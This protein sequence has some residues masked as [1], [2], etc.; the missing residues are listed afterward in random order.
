MEFIYNETPE[1]V[2]AQLAVIAAQLIID[3]PSGIMVTMMANKGINIANRVTDCND[4]IVL[5]ISYAA[6][7]GLSKGK[8]FEGNKIQKEI[9]THLRNIGQNGK[10]VLPF[11]T[12]LG[13][14][15]YDIVGGTLIKIPTTP[16]GLKE[17]ATALQ[18]K[19][20]SFVLP[21]CP[22]SP[23]IATKA[24]N[25]PNDILAL[26]SVITMKVDA[27][28]LRQEMVGITHTIATKMEAGEI[29]L[30]DFA[31]VIIEV[32]GEDPAAAAKYGFKTRN[33]PTVEKD[34]ITNLLPTEF[35][36]LEHVA[37]LTFIKNPTNQDLWVRKGKK[38]TGAYEIIKANSSFLVTYGYG[39]CTIQNPS[40]TVSSKVSAT[41]NKK[42][43]A[44]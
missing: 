44:A 14:Y 42:A 40:L 1:E 20:S 21:V 7:D 37:K 18:L 17:L 8:V 30:R 29:N 22:L 31:E 4:C 13:L 35:K 19:I 15:G 9:S 24:Y 5:E 39:N 3:G 25:I 10:S 2:K 33:T 27:K 16:L 6:K 41:I 11:I 32:Y 12:D 26:A 23:Y 43:K 38:R 28:Q 36:G 34:Q